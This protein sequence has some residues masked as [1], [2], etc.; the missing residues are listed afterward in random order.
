MS[1]RKP[2]NTDPRDLAN[3]LDEAKVTSENTA[4][5]RTEAVDASIRA[6]RLLEQKLKAALQDEPLRGLPN[7]GSGS[8]PQHLLR[9]RVRTRLGEPLEDRDVLC[10]DHTGVLVMARNGASRRVRDDEI[11]AGDAQDFA[12]ALGAALERHIEASDRASS[13]N[14]A[15]LELSRRVET[16]IKG[17]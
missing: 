12:Y 4:K 17:E 10:L 2:K 11:L 15:L 16:A 7:L 14:E 1:P 13:R 5:A 3:L 9:V 8:R 6:C